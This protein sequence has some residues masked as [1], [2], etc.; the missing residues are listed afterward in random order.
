MPFPTIVAWNAVLRVGLI[1]TAMLHVQLHTNKTKK[2]SLL[3]FEIGMIIALSFT[4]WAFNYSSLTMEYVPEISG[5]MHID[6]DITQIGTI[7]IEP[8]EPQDKNTQ[9]ETKKFTHNFQIVP[10]PT[11]IPEPGPEPMPE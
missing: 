6:D 9:K 8:D 5:D 11:P 1:S 4:L 3:F 10:D 7:T 2:R